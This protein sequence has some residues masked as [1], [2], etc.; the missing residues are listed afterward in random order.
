MPA[1]DTPE[2]RARR[3]TDT[4]LTA[5]RWVVQDRADTNLSAGLGIA[6]REF[7]MAAEHGFADYLLLVEGQAVGALEAKPEG[8]PLSGV[9]PRGSCTHKACRLR[10][11]RFPSS[12]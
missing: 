3:R 1:P 6:I 2:L 4:A 9:E 11:G 8:Y 5:S 10:T 7:R 12:T